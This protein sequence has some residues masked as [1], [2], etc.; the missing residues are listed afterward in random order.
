MRLRDA[1]SWLL[2]MRLRDAASWLLGMRKEIDGPGSRFRE[3]AS[4][5]KVHIRFRSDAVRK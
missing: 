3:K 4:D 1:A 2:G 5:R